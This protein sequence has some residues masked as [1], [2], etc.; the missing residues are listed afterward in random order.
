MWFTEIARW[1]RIEG[2]SYVPIA[3][4]CV[5]DLQ[6]ALEARG[7]GPCGARA[8]AI[9]IARCS[10]IRGAAEIDAHR[11]PDTNG[12]IRWPTGVLKSLL[13]DLWEESSPRIDT[14]RR[15]I[16]D[17][18]L[19]C[20]ADELVDLVVLAVVGVLAWSG[21]RNQL[22]KIEAVLKPPQGEL[23]QAILSVLS[24]DQ[25]DQTT[26]ANTVA[27]LFDDRGRRSVERTPIA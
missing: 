21:A 8:V 26:F 17:D 15:A 3:R 6:S 20:V 2:L 23:R 1:R 13:V 9:T 22:P 4:D 11:K 25:A 14:A 12:S 7:I 27:A 19:P 5:N 18:A 24:S 16:E 10:K